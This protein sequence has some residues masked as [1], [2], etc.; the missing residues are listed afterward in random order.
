MRQTTLLF[1]AAALL[2]AAVPAG[3]KPAYLKACKDA[4]ITQVTTCKSCHA[5]KFTKDSLNDVG[6]WLV[7]QKAE[8]KAK[9]V[10]PT[11]VKAYFAKK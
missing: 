1:A 2:V 3:A 10:D 5:E 9:E 11:W 7:K 6:K 8:K 4:G